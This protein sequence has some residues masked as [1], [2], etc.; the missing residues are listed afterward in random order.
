MIAKVGRLHHPSKSVKKDKPE[1]MGP[2]VSLSAVAMSSSCSLVS[3]MFG[4][5]QT[6]AYVLLLLVYH[7]I[8]GKIII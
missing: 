4:G 3:Y 1:R 5:R 8:L 2:T 7:L 6:Q